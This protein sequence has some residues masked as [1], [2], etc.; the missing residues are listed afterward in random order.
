M[1][2]NM[3]LLAVLALCLLVMGGCGSSKEKPAVENARIGVMVGSTN[4]V[5]AGTHYPKAKLQR[6]NNYVDSL[7]ALRGNKID[8]AMMDY[9][10]ALNAVR[11]NTDVAIVSDF[12][13]DEKLCLGVNKNNPE[14]YEKVYALVNQYLEDGTMDEMIAHWIKKDGSAYDTPD[15]K[16]LDA[17]PVLNV[18]VI[19]TREPTTFM[20]N[21]K[22]AGLDIE[23]WYRIAYDLG[24]QLKFYDMELSSLISAMGSDKMD[25]C[26][27]IYST[28]ERAKLVL[29]TE[30]Y[31]ANPQVLLSKKEAD[32]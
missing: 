23:L 10:S 9:T 14:L 26:L 17:G 12:L 25:V 8:Y 1:K 19:L 28:P 7:A 27:G 3:M 21:G 2:K 29:L 18:A 20:L 4:D 15:Y 13:T 11:Y 22:E 5:Y 30:P 32:K 16:I 6:Y 24:Y 31:F